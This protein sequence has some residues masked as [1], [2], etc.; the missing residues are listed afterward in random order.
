MGEAALARA[1]ELFSIDR[2][3]NRM[4]E[5]LRAAAR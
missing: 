1:L 3:V 2:H 4:E 5:V